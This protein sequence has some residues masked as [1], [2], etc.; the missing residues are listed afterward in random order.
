MKVIYGYLIRAL[1]RGYVLVAASLLSLFGLFDFMEQADDVGEASFSVLDAVAVVAL[2]LPVRLVDL[3]PFVA[4]IGVV[5]GLSTFVRS[6]ELIAMR[7]AGITPLRLT[8]L[9]GVATAG[10]FALL[11]GMEFAA[12]PMA[13]QA[14][15]L[16]MAE[17]SREG[18]L[19]SQDGIWIEHEGLF[20]NI[21]SLARA[22]TPS[23]IRMYE[24][25]GDTELDRFIEADRAAL[26]T[27]GTWTL[28]GVVEK[29][30]LDGVAVTTERY[31]TLAWTPPWQQ[32]T[33]LYELPIE[34]LSLAEINEYRKYLAGE[35]RPTGIYAMEFW[36]RIFT[37]ASG[38]VFAL[39]AA[40]F[41]LGV[42]PRASMGGAVSLGVANALGLFLVQQ[43]GTNA[44]F[45]TTHSP[46]LAVSLPIAL[47]MG[48]AAALIR[49]V[50]G[51]PR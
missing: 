20:V 37:P 27:E 49:R 43:I 15:L 44:I 21:E 5:Y 42:R 30:Y 36:R 25:G 14:H 32:S 2:N 23:G 4:L 19:F 8:V 46:L 10:F 18:A 47:V 22:G 48:V 16:H 13:Q 29:R 9:C 31:P 6:Q 41:V 51:A 40:P 17:T 35:A 12:R 34:S 45:L 50:N 11:A 24:F 33:A 28:R 3:S 38:I 26:G 39:F 7:A 1:V